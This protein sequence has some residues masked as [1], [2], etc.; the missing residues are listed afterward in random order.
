MGGAGKNLILITR[1]LVEARAFAEDVKGIGF[2]AMIE[3]MLA[4]VPKAYPPVDFDRYVGLIFTSVHAVRVFGCPDAAPLMPVFAVG[5]HTARAA[6]DLG[7]DIVYSAGGDGGDLAELFQL[8]TAAVSHQGIFLHICGTHTGF[9]LAEVLRCKGIMVDAL[10]VYDAEAATCLTDFC[11][12]ALEA[13]DVRA[14]T[15]FSKRTAENFVQLARDAGV[16]SSLSGIK[17]LC[18]SPAVLE[19]VRSVSWGEA[20]AATRPDRVSMIELIRAACH[21]NL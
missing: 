3:P 1:P 19:S 9:P 5:D 11:L 12:A 8:K 7:Y 14:V 15:L 6:R 13:G 2:D 16:I 4:I 20:Y 17:A 10:I 21:Q 18:I